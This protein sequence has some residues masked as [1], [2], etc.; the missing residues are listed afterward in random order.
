MRNLP[1]LLAAAVAL[2]CV[3]SLAEDI[4]KAH[5]DATGGMKAI[6]AVKTFERSGSVE[7]SGMMGD[8]AGTFREAA[9]AEKKAFTETDLG[10]YQESGGW[11]GE[12]GWSK[13]SFEGL[14]ELQGDELEN[15]QFGMYVNPIASIY[16]E[17][18]AAAFEDKGEVPI[19][20]RVCH[21]LKVVDSELVFF[22]DKET[23]MCSGILIPFENP[24]VGEGEVR[25]SMGD[26]QEHGGITWPGKLD[27][28][29]MD[30]V[31]VL[32]YTYEKTTLNGEID[33]SIFEKP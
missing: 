24:D 21:A 3:P 30:G 31:F 22:I 17:Y 11:N 23:K 1:Y 12:V 25:I 19:G 27:V 14:K 18:G 13:N 6:Q 7:M 26:Y 8:G 16:A 10:I 5:I 33:E 2:L 28:D 32:N 15:V 9:I 4:A 20:D 29:V